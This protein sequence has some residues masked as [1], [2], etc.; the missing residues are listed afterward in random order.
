MA[1]E[2][3]NFGSD[4]TE[5]R[6][7]LPV[8]L[9]VLETDN[10]FLMAF[11]YLLKVREGDDEA[12]AAKKKRLVKNIKYQQLWRNHYDN[13]IIRPAQKLISS[14]FSIN[15]MYAGLIEILFIFASIKENKLNLNTDPKDLLKHLGILQKAQFADFEFETDIKSLFRGDKTH[16]DINQKW[17][18]PIDKDDPLFDFWFSLTLRQMPVQKINAFLN[19]Q[20]EL[21][22]EDFSLYLKSI[23]ISYENH[24]EEKTKKAVFEYL[25]KEAPIVNLETL[26]VAAKNVAINSENIQT[27]SPLKTASEF[28]DAEFIT[29]NFDSYRIDWKAKPDDIRK[30]LSF[31]YEEKNGSDDYFLIDDDDIQHLKNYGIAIPTA[32]LKKRITLNLEGDKRSKKVVLTMFYKFFNKIKRNRNQKGEMVK[33]LKHTFTNFDN[34]KTKK[35]PNNFLKPYDIA[36]QNWKI[37]KSNYL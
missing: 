9:K 24:Y 29:P 6:Y 31:L 25:P 21:F 30:F 26:N 32:P 7:L 17:I 2:H 8:N 15:K 11:N 33:F 14:P 1:L 27:S 5:I 28:L 22:H 18:D 10:I 13:L 16:D 37:E 36:V 4:I 12:K 34:Y 20:K 23:L 19:F 3:L 35:N